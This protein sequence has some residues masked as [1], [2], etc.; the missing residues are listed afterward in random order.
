MRNAL[1]SLLVAVLVCNSCDA[2]HAARIRN[3][4]R[5]HLVSA[6]KLAAL[7]VQPPAIAVSMPAPVSYGV[8]SYI[9]GAF[10]GVRVWRRPLVI[11]HQ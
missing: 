9:A 1:F 3:L 4:N 6:A 7:G 10:G 8:G 5:K 11:I 2:S